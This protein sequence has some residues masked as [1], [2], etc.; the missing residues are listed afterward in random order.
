MLATFQEN[1]SKERCPHEQVIRREP[2]CPLDGC[3]DC[4]CHVG[5]TRIV[6]AGKDAAEE[7]SA[8]IRPEALRADMRF[9][10]DDLL[11]GRG[12][13]TRGHEIVAKFM[14]SEFEAM[15]LEPAG[16]DESYFQSVPLRAIEP[17][18]EPFNS[19]PLARRK[20]PILRKSRCGHCTLC[21]GA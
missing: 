3:P 8:A 14:A 17:D 11:E 21:A 12:T 13:G 7:T 9:R 16:D 19:E 2:P 15:G 5:G 10:A 1:V 18:Q 20:R 6:L 4:L